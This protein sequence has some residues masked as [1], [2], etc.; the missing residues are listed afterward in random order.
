MS[1]DEGFGVEE[2]ATDGLGGD[3][4]EEEL[5]AGERVENEPG[6]GSCLGSSDGRFRDG[7][8]CRWFRSRV[9]LLWSS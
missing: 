1:V 6:G 2:G 8:V 3:E 7:V 9:A 4:I 5:P